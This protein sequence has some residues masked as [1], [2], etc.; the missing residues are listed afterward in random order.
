MIG[1][2]DWTVDPV[3]FQIGARGVRWY[4]ILLALGFLLGYLIFSRIAKKEGLKQDLVDK[5]AIVVIL[6]VVIG[7]RLGHCL[8]YNPDYYL[9]NPVEILKVW[10]GGL[11][12]HGGA[13]GILIAVW[14]F[15]RKRKKISFL[16]IIDR[17]AIIATLAGAFV[18]IGNLI[19]HEIVGIPTQV[20]WA[21]V[22]HRVDMLPRHPTQLYESIFYFICFA[23]MITFYYRRNWGAREGLIT[24]FFFTAVF[25]FR[26]VIEFT[27]TVQMETGG[28][29]FPLRMGQLLSIPFV[30]I[31]IWLMW[32]AYRRPPL[33]L[34]FDNA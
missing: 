5:L 30:I 26:F 25:A 22:F 11:A 24:G 10:K 7:L 27:K 31:G 32:R 33:R 28:W 1:F 20:P 18:R 16:Y 34:P 23:L 21:F 4:G 12:S 3:A 15:Q 29:D 19:N 8:F 2:I 9:S 14:L 17:L 13:A 6:G